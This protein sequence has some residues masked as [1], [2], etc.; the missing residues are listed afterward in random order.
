ME[1]DAMGFRLRLREGVEGL[2]RIGLYGIRKIGGADDG[3][4][5]AQVPVGMGFIGNDNVDLRAGDG[6]TGCLVAGE[7]ESGDL[8]FGEF[9]LEMIEVGPDIDEGA[10]KHVAGGPGDGVDVE[11]ANGLWLRAGGCWFM[12]VGMLAGV[13]VV[14]FM[15]V[16]VF[17][18]VAAAAIRPV[19]V[20]VIV[21]MMAVI[22]THGVG[23]L[24][25]GE[26][27]WLS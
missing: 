23:P 9:R 5:I 25:V 19:L 3:N 7:L 18:A 13:M 21:V 26:E 20:L 16:V 10:K 27:G 22:V 1:G 12:L 6:L 15:V 24:S 17:M 4:E 11:D 2:Q 8:E 14:V